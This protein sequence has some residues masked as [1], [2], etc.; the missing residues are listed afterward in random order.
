M[1]VLPIRSGDALLIVDLQNDFLL[2][3]AL[4]V[5]GGDAVIE[6]LNRCIELFSAAALPI[7][8]TRDWHPADHCSFTAQGGIWPPHC[9]AGSAGAAFAAK[10]R[11]PPGALLLS[12]ATTAESDAYSGFE[13]TALARQLRELGVRRLFVGGLA[14]D[15]CVLNTVRDARRLGFEV[16]LLLDTIRAVEVQAGDGARAIAQMVADGAVSATVD[17]LRPA[18]LGSAAASAAPAQTGHHA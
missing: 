9:M 11:L 13:G 8:A 6:P 2:G 18:P 15:Y 4:A 12:K 5:A 3:G 1:P 17:A 10:L 14:T 16:V 7:V